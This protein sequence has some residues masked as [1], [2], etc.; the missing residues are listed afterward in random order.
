MSKNPK[1]ALI[2]EKL[3]YLH[4]Q[5]IPLLFY[6]SVCEGTEQGEEDKECQEVTE[7][8][9]QRGVRLS[10]SS[11]K[12]SYFAGNRVLTSAEI[13][14]YPDGTLHEYRM[15]ETWETAESGNRQRAYVGPV[16]EDRVSLEDMQE[17]L[18]FNLAPD[19]EDDEDGDWV[20]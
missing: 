18:E 7:Y 19:Y 6:A 1:R 11:P 8:A 14:L 4:F 13:W 12:R 17:A 10:L 15:S 3:S 9:K 16:G 5:K 2:Q 20:Y